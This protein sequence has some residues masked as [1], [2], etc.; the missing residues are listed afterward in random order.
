MIPV[1]WDENSPRPAGTDLTLRLHVEMKF[2][3][4]K[5]GQLAFAYI[6]INFFEFV[7]VIMSVYEFKTHRLHR[8]PT[9]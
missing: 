3:P 9:I 6:C 8:F 4:S 1:C 7:F 5:V 2:R